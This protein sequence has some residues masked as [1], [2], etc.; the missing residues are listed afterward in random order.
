M[1]GYM[2]KLEV[3]GERLRR[4]VWK[5]EHLEAERAVHEARV[6]QIAG[7]LARSLQGQTGTAAQKALA[8]YL[9]A[10]QAPRAEEQEMN[11]KMETALMAYEGVDAA[12]A[13]GLENQM[14][15]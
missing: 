7:D 1:I 12:A 2:A 14:G 11:L 15:I 3:D 8:D 10:S 4:E 13:G 5:F 9:A 6:A